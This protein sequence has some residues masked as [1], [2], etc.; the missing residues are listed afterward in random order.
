MEP[1]T[2]DEHDIAP[3][4][5]GG[6]PDSPPDAEGHAGLA[7]TRPPIAWM[8]PG[9]PFARPITITVLWPDA[10]VCVPGRAPAETEQPLS[11]ARAV[12][13]IILA[14]PVAAVGA[15]V[16]YSVGKSFEPADERWLR[17]ADSMGLGLGAVLA[18]ILLVWLGNR[19][20]SSIGLTMRQWHLD[21][22]IGFASLL[23]TWV[24]LL[25]FGGVI[26]VLFPSVLQEQSAAQKAIE[27]S[28]PKL[29]WQQMLALCLCIAIYEEIVF[30]GFLLTRLH[31]L[32]RGWW[33]AVVIGA[34]LFGLPHHYQGWWAVCGITLLG[35]IMGSL[36]AWRK[37]LVAPITMHL[38]HNFAVFMLLDLVSGM[39]N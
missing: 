14:V 18:C 25:A 6:P 7:V 20:I 12:I 8:A 30:R 23:A 9:M 2:P 35:L 31:A 5:Q 4:P 3:P 28:F 10:P 11:R 17:I 34:V 26:V 36:F 16:G 38:F 19:K 21:L 29:S 37:S 24:V 1:T 22:G 32:V 33:L 39:R 15:V 27:A 13:E